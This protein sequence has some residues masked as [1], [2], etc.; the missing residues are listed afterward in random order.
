MHKLVTFQIFLWIHRCLEFKF[1][2]LHFFKLCFSSSFLDFWN[3]FVNITRYKTFNSRTLLVEFHFPVLFPSHCVDPTFKCPIN[4]ERD[5]ESSINSL[6]PLSL[7]NNRIIQ[8]L[9]KLHSSNYLKSRHIQSSSLFF[10]FS[11]FIISILEIWISNN[12]KQFF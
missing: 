10:P 5:S 4:S 6:S 7:L 8:I 9:L 12:S 3:T 2:L 11:S 1:F